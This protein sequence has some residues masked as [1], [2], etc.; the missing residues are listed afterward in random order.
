MSEP[1]NELPKEWRAAAETSETPEM[2]PSAPETP[3]R[4]R[5]SARRKTLWGI[6]LSIA[7]VGAAVAGSHVFRARHASGAV[8]WV[9]TEV[10]GGVVITPIRLVN[11]L[12]EG[13]L[14][15]LRVGTKAGKLQI[16]RGPRLNMKDPRSKGTEAKG[17]FVPVP[18][19]P[20]SR[21][22]RATPEVLFRRYSV[23]VSVQSS[24][25][26]D[27]DSA[28]NELAL[29]PPDALA[30]APSRIEDGRPEHMQPGFGVLANLTT[31]HTDSFGNYSAIFPKGLERLNKNRMQANGIGVYALFNPPTGGPSGCYGNGMFESDSSEVME[32]QA[33]PGAV[34]CLTRSSATFTFTEGKSANG[35]VLKH[36]LFRPGVQFLVVEAVAGTQADAETL[37]ERFEQALK[38]T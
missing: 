33:F 19:L 4:T 16:H 29:N 14:Q 24:I 1:W 38:L 2:S 21:A 22:G 32:T 9:E 18:F 37:L 10:S 28:P 8:F 20:T 13:Y 36:Y 31:P 7:L 23:D 12:D 15:T 35:F 5:A 17:F 11:D 34:G 6:A 30:T 25:L 26:P 27:P 3:R